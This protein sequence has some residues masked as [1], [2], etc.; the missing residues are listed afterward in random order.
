MQ[1]MPFFRLIRPL[2]LLMILFTQY[3]VRYALLYPIFKALAGIGLQL[4]ETI[5]ALLS[6]AFVLMAAGGYIINDY[7]DVKIDTVNKPDKV[8]IGRQLKPVNALTLYWIL[9]I[10]GLASGCW[11]SYKMGLPALSAVFFIYFVGLWFYSY[12]LKYI[13]FAGNFIVAFF[14]ALVPFV[15]GIVELFAF[16]E[17]FQ[18]HDSDW[19]PKV[20]VI[21]CVV[22]IFAFLATLVREIVKDM[23]D[24]EGD[25]T[26]G[27]RTLPVVMGI[28]G[29]KRVAQFFLLIVI[30]LSGFVE[31]WFCTGISSGFFTLRFLLPILYISCLIQVPSFW[32]IIRLNMASL[33]K[34]FHKVSNWLKI[35]ML[36]GIS[37]LFV[38]AYLCLR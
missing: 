20:F 33:S 12:K 35:L 27:C 18:L 7:Y 13:F 24:I 2:N 25:V 3:M 38:F 15:S 21:V 1:L 23:E 5:F 37:Y 32:I 11:A 10:V 16:T 36:T 17:H 8:I 31:Y 19:V 30:F 14:I 28:T 22:S 9:S 29:A 6:F 34:H 4:H 26:Q